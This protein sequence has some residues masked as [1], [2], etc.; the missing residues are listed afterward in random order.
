M[1]ERGYS[2]IKD[3]IKV[4]HTVVTDIIRHIATALGLLVSK[5]K[6]IHVRTNNPIKK[7]ASRDMALSTVGLE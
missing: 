1:I 2:G 6:K 3:S 7:G 4:W 5:C